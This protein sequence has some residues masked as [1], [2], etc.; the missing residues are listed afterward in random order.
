VHELSLV[1]SIVETCRECAGTARVRR[2]TLEVG[3]LCCVMPEALRFCFVA[4]TE[5]TALAG[6]A[7]EILPQPGRSRCRDCGR[8]VALQSL[9]DL[10]A[11][12]SG[13]LAPPAGGDQ[14]RIHSMEIEEAV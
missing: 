13:N 3:T 10:C 1:Q 14:L 12:G 2:V 5:G 6:A 11:C 9:L 4:V 7:L 8:T